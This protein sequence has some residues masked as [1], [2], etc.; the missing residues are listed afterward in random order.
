MSTPR[1]CRR[2]KIKLGTPYK[3]STKKGIKDSDLDDDSVAASEFS[4]KEEESEEELS[5]CE[6]EREDD[7]DS[8]YA[9]EDK[10]TDCVIDIK[11]HRIV[12][13]NTNVSFSDQPN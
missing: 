2:K 9:D 7:N 12:V 10:P 3:S 11:F 5:V 13:S 4:E 6:S 1:K 8:L